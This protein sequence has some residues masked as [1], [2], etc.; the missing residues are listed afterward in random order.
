MRDC[1]LVIDQGTTSTRVMVFDA[2]GRRQAVTQ[3]ALTPI[4]PRP[5]WVEHDPEEIWQ[6]VTLCLREACADTDMARRI[7]AVG[8]TNQRETTLLWDR[9]T[10]KALHNAIVWQD[11]RTA[12]VCRSLVESGH[13]AAVAA[14]TGLVID[15][16]FSATKLRWLLDSVSDMPA[17]RLA[18]GTVDSFLLWRLT[19]GRAHATDATNAARTLLFD[20]H[21]LAWS[22]PLLELFGIPRVILPEVRPTAHVFGE[23][24]A[25]L[26]GHAAPVTAMAGDQHAALAGQACLAPGTMKC[27]YGTGAFAMV[28]TGASV[29]ASQHGLLS[30]LAWQLG[31]TATYALEGSIFNA[32]TAVQWLR[33]GLGIIDSAAH[34]E[35]LAQRRGGS[36][37]IMVPAFTGLGA[38]HWDADARG[39]IFGL[40]RD[41]GPADL[42]AAALDA[43]CFQTADLISA[44]RAD[45][46]EPD[47]LR[48]DG[49]MAENRWFGQRLA[50]IL[51]L[52]VEC[53]AETEATALGAAH[54]AR[55]GA[56]LIGDLSEA[57]VW[58]P[59]ARYRPQLAAAVRT[60][61]LARWSD[62]VARVQTGSPD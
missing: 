20:I 54:L 12:R 57:A 51:G 60:E 26:F 19:G 42:A 9:E 22:G 23:C 24:D 44:M 3:R 11:R 27:T 18:F 7:A 48:I 28:N 59:A 47:S 29:L 35:L 14:V 56:G 25:A 6:S 58:R 62:A 5:G 4:Y 39:A 40:T 8:I 61:Q 13:G 16:Y 36:K 37:V 45:G 46:A 17:E 53:G 38:P 33:D 49:G 32:G 41:S 1:V 34:T 15:P 2:D 31:D 21:R 30:T 50:D 10:G 55:L 43:V 52:P